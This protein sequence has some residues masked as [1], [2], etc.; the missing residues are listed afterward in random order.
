MDRREGRAGRTAAA[1]FLAGVLAAGGAA[2]TGP[3]P[4]PGA[5]PSAASTAQENP[6]PARP[7]ATDGSASGSGSEDIVTLSGDHG[8]DTCLEGFVWREARPDDH[9]CVEPA[10][11]DQVRADNVRSDTTTGLGSKECAPGR[12]WREAYPGDTVCVEPRVRD[13]AREDNARA[14]DRRVSLRLWAGN[15]HRET[16]CDPGGDCERGADQPMLKLNGS[17]YNLDRIRLAVRAAKDDRVLWTATVK[18][19]PHAGFPGGSFGIRT[20]RGDCSA[21]G[22]APVRAYAVAYDVVSGRSSARLPVT[23]CT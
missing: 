16:T 20:D 1:V 3:A 15:W 4:E 18:G 13:R 17:G 10:V 2:C 9:V 23:V 8:P 14:A 11:R 12:V 5:A 7:G 21:A 19:T 22:T 6:D